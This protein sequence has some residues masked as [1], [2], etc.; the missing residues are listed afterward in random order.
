MSDSAIIGIK[1]IHTL[2]VFV[3]L[4][5]FL[6]KAFLLFTNKK[7]QLKSYSAKTRIIFDMIVPV[8]FLSAGI[9]MLTQIGMKNMGGWFHLKLTLFVIL[10][11]LG[12]IGF[13]KQN[14]LMAGL[15]LVILIYLFLLA[16]LKNPLLIF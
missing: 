14:K 11:P 12:I 7:T 4:I 3:F 2:L 8:L 10:I 9:Y 1:H 13:K 5:S 16:F 6:I 15:A